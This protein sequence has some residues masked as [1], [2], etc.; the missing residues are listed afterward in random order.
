MPG[1]NTHKTDLISYCKIF[2]MFYV[3]NVKSFVTKLCLFRLNNLPEVEIIPQHAGSF[4]LYHHSTVINVSTNLNSSPIHNLDP[5]P[6]WTFLLQCCIHTHYYERRKM[7][8]GFRV[9]LPMFCWCLRCCESWSSVIGQHWQC[10]NV[11]K[12]PAISC[13]KSYIWLEQ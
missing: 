3:N 9:V 2:I 5:Y 6:H 8:A 13:C 10:D 12:S 1:I 4:M 7:R 11:R